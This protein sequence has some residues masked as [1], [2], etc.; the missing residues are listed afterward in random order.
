MRAVIIAAGFG[1]RLSDISDCKPLAK[2]RGLALIEWSIRQAKRAGIT[3]FTVVTGHQATRLEQ[4][5]SRIAPRLGVEID[6]VRVDDWSR[7]NGFSV[8]AGAAAE[9]APFLL[10]M[11]DHIFA[12]D[13]LE[14]LTRQPLDQCGVVLA[15]DRRVDHPLIDPEDATWVETGECASIRAIGKR[16]TRYNA[17]DCGAFLASAE[18]VDAIEQ[19][20]ATG[21]AGSLSDGMQWLADRG[22]ARA[23]DIGESWWIDVDDPRSHYQAETQMPAEI[24]A[25]AGEVQD[26][27]AREQAG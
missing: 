18:L 8:M 3:Q 19:A 20:I 9:N 14:R 2:V 7:P 23:M 13:I 11:A 21:A 27:Q 10:M 12:S 16:I 1:S 25:G 15:V 6:A 24:D 5:L 4:E 26:T 17:A 22:R